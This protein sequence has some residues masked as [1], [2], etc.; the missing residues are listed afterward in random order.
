MGAENK[1]EAAAKPAVDEIDQEMMSSVATRLG[2]SLPKTRDDDAD[3]SDAAA[4]NQRKDNDDD[5]AG[6]GA[7]K[8]DGSDAGDEN[9]DADGK[10]KDEGDGGDAGDADAEEKGDGEEAEKGENEAGD[11]KPGDEYAKETAKLLEKSLKELPAD[12]R[13]KVETVIG[14]R[15]G[16]IVAKERTERERMG[17]R[18]EELTQENEQ[19]AAE[20]GPRFV[21]ADVHPTLLA[22]SEAELGDRKSKLDK[23]IDWAEDNADGVNLPDSDGYDESKPTYTKDHVRSQARMWKR[24]RDELI[25]Q[26][27]ETL[28]ARTKGDA[29]LKEAF[30]QL[31]DAKSAE[32]ATG[33]KFLKMMPQLKRY[34]NAN[35]I[36]AAFVLGQAKLEELLGAKAKTAGDKEK[37]K[38]KNSETVIRKP[39]PRAPGSGSQAKGS[40]VTRERDKPAMHAAVNKAYQDPSD[41]KAF[42]DAVGA[43]TADLL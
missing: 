42:K 11:K 23:W 9:A 12:T 41:K 30:P 16:Q 39:A 14:S 32:Y 7:D 10:S 38:N 3:G 27:R 17:A 40:V 19:L 22:E 13:K 26:V 8:G 6:D 5:D 4:E 1:G 15:I 31:F 43:L 2:S 28:R 29:V 35:A 18:V 24:E 21:S 36:A 33:K 20:K 25:P 34:A 37:A